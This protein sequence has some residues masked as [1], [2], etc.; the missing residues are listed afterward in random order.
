V[1]VSLLVSLRS[2]RQAG[3]GTINDADQIER[4]VVTA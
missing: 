2:Q 1:D 4:A 3:T